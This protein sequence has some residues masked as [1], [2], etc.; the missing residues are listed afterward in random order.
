M[1]LDN[2][3][4]SIIVSNQHQQNIHLARPL[5][6]QP[7]LVLLLAQ[8]QLAT[9]VLALLHHLPVK[10]TLIWTTTKSLMG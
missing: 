1:F 9:N 2:H 8:A 3:N 7:L 6:P 4:P 10:Q 5:T